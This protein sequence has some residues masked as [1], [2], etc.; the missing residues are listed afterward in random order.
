MKKLLNLSYLKLKI[1]KTCLIN[2]ST[3][4]KIST[5]DIR[6]YIGDVANIG[7]YT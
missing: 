1:S 6:L 2:K 3:I 4:Y 7:K 5:Y